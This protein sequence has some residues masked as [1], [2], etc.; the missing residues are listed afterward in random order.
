LSAM[1]RERDCG[2]ALPQ[3]NASPPLATQLP[4]PFAGGIKLV[5]RS[6]SQTLIVCCRAGASARATKSSVGDA[7]ALAKLTR[8]KRRSKMQAPGAKHSVTRAGWRTGDKGSCLRLPQAR[9]SPQGRGRRHR[10]R[11]QSPPAL[12]GSCPGEPPSGA[13]Q[14]LH[15]RLEASLWNSL[16]RCDG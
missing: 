13:E 1:S 6:L 2:G 14:H 15:T 8:C 7:A 16:P 11:L 5:W 4:L 12:R 3:R 10:K 9:D